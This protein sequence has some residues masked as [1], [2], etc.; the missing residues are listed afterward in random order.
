ML[1]QY[2]LYVPRL[3]DEPWSGARIAPGS[4]VF[5]QLS[6]LTPA[7]DDIAPGN[8][9]QVAEA[10]EV[11]ASAFRGLSEAA[12]AHGGD[13][14][15]FGASSLCVLFTGDGRQ[16]RAINAVHAMH[17]A[18][19]GDDAQ[20]VAGQISMSA[21][22][23]SGMVHLVT[24]GKDPRHLISI[25]PTVTRAIELAT[26]GGPGDTRAERV[27]RSGM[28]T[29]GR[30]VAWP[31]ADFLATSIQD[32]I[33]SDRREP[34]S[35]TAAIGYAVFS[36]VDRALQ[37]NPARTM[38]LVDEVV[39]SVQH[40][41][42]AFGITILGNG[43][44]PGGGTILLAAGLPDASDDAEERMFQAASA[45]LEDDPPLA[46]RFGVATGP[47]IAGSIGD[48]KRRS[49]TVFG[50]TVEL[51]ARLAASASPGEILSTHR[52]IDRATTRYV[53]S[54]LEPVTFRG[55]DWQVVPVAVGPELAS[56]RGGGGFV[57]RS[58]ERG[59]LARSIT[60][61]GE[62]RGG[63]VDIVG[64]AGVGKS[65][66]VAETLRDTE[67]RTIEIRC[68]QYERCNPYSTAS[69]VLR[70]TMGIGDD[71]DPKRVGALL[72]ARVREL[73]P[74]LEPWLP[75]LAEV[76]G[77]RVRM[78]K[79][80]RALS[81]RC[82]QQRTESAVSQ[83]ISWLIHEP[84]VVSIEDAH[85]M[86]GSSA[87][88]LFFV[89]AGSD[90]PCLV[91]S[92]RRPFAPGQ[93]PS[94]DRAGAAVIELGPL[95]PGA[96][97]A[98][99]TELRKDDPVPMKALSA[100]IDRAEGNPMFMELLALGDGQ[101]EAMP[102]DLG[103]AVKAQIDRL[104]PAPRATIQQASVF[105]GDFVPDEARDLFAGVDWATVADFI[106]PAPAG[107][108][109]FRHASVRDAVYAGLTA[110]QRH[111]F[112]DAVA[113]DLV[114]AAPESAAATIHFHQA[115]NHAEVWTR[116]RLA[117]TS[118]LEQGAFNEGAALFEM[119]L[120][121]SGHV[122]A[123]T[124]KDIAETAEL[125][126]DACQRAGRPED[127]DRAYV[128]SSAGFRANRDKARLLAKRAGVR[129]RD[130][131]YPAALR[132]LTAAIKS[133]PKRSGPGDHAA[134]EYRYARVRF[135]QAKYRDAIERGERATAQASRVGDEGTLGRAH[136]LI[137]RARSRL[138]PGAGSDDLERALEIFEDRSDHLMQAS[139]LGHL[140]TDAY[141]RG[142]YGEALKYQDRNAKHRELAGD[143]IGAAMA[144]YRRAV[145]LLDQGKLDEAALA[146]ERVRVA[147]R[148]ANSPIGTARS[149]MKAAEID[150]RRGNTLLALGMLE[151]AQAQF[152]NMGNDRE[153]LESRL[154]Q[155]EAALLAGDV[156]EA[157]ATAEKA[158]EATE[159][160]EGIEPVKIGLQRVRGVA[161]V[162]IGKSKEG[163][164]Q[165]M[166]ALEAAQAAPAAFEEALVSDALAK[167]YGDDEAAEHRDEIMDRLGIIKLPPFL[168]V[169]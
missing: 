9:G 122:D 68:D 3:L 64:E 131:R 11:V 72:Q 142:S 30:A 60:A 162:W 109:R 2:S 118:A 44:A 143:V 112:H 134:L 154:V 123:A 166:G 105:G 50:A 110:R 101:S 125:F 20:A 41:A 85:W 163:Y 73:T 77:G 58:E 34:A 97:R 90:L 31:A 18:L 69:K 8:N 95:A 71:E 29:R 7:L 92:T 28:A 103:S 54:E 111:A 17:E 82:R 10:A 124:K 120:E 168:T 45:A 14:L 15:S 115:A 61:L 70:A 113:K 65:R 121:S 46:L 4:F 35:A 43:V 94:D 152:E 53:I 88:L 83:L 156:E 12:Y 27:D 151:I 62:G 136:L 164:V 19:N 89:F 144:S 138:E 37:R 63:V 167:L 114:E 104:A 75:L 149:T 91:V 59:I 79:A 23:A 140:G 74:Y 169:S 33:E 57:G 1:N 93:A 116:G 32:V 145:V 67:F 132:M 26:A 47:I 159:G 22:I 117:A 36:G 157:L 161:L 139:A 147:S 81:D 16:G 24:S 56:D 84:L 107:R 100:M 52:A 141:R 80:V 106:E 126:G 42:A 150:A 130:G 6:G 48:A 13:V 38:E 76:I 49:F 165:L 51:A 155:S 21:G 78:T 86:D 5:C 119:A 96:A 102:R 129:E 39:D 55:I 133:L 137:G 148:A 146:L 87:D 135:S 160:V 99:L 40:S 98:L 25:G 127:A 66:L 128:A 153:A 158:L 108:L